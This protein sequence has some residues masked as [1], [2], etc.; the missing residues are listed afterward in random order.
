M[1]NHLN[2]I[3]PLENH[4]Y[5]WAWNTHPTDPMRIVIYHWSQPVMSLFLGEAMES[6]GY[7]A[8]MQH[9]EECN[10]TPWL[11]RWQKERGQAI[12]DA[13]TKTYESI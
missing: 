12:T 5:E 10:S 4:P 1:S 9:V 3:P 6:A 2:D 7:H 8:V 11:R 13:L